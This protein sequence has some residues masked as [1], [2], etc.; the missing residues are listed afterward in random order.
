MDPRGQAEPR[1]QQGYPTPA[2]QGLSHYLLTLSPNSSGPNIDLWGRE[3]LL[4]GAGH[5]PMGGEKREA[6]LTA[7][8][9]GPGGP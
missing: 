8:P 2:S 3:E 4:D 7:R 9:G 1:G 6:E 5:Q